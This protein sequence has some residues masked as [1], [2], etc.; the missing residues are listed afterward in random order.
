MSL[1]L[2]VISFILPLVSILP[3]V[4][5]LSLHMDLGGKLNSETLSL[6]QVQWL[7]VVP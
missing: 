3:I 6:R 4:S 5:H 2:Y 1:S 7:W